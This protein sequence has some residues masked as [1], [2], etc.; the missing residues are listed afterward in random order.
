MLSASPPLTVTSKVTGTEE[1]SFYADPYADFVGPTFP[2]DILPLVLTDFV[3]AQRQA[4]GADLA[5]LSMAVLT[6]VAGAMH[7]ETKVKMGDGWFEPP[8]IWTALIGAP[9]AMKSPTIDKVIKP[10]RKTDADRDAA[11]RI[12]KTHWQQT[13]AGGQ[14]RGPCPP[15]PARCLVQDATAEKIAEILSRDPAGSLMVQDELAGLLG[16]F[17]RYSSGHPRGRSS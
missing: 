4:M 10:L 9:S 6:A 5:A 16:S 2:V 3:D 14:N 8:I 11:W 1:P 13:K 7:A 15:K 17:E 12:Q